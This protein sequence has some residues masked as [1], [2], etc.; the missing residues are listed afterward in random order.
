VPLQSAALEL[1]KAAT[2]DADRIRTTLRLLEAALG[3]SDLVST[4]DAIQQD[5]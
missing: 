3:Q 1:L 4:F 5:R 2:A